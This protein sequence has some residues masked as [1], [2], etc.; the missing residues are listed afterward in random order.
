MILPVAVRT[1]ADGPATRAAYRAG[2]RP[3]R[4]LLTAP[5]LTLAALG[6]G[7][8]SAPASW[9]PTA[10]V[11][12]SSGAW[13]PELAVNARGDAAVAWSPTLERQSAT[14][15]VR[16][17]TRRGPAGTFVTRTVMRRADTAIG[18][19]TVA[20]DP[21]GEAT[22]AWVERRS[23]R[24]LLSGPISVKAAYRRV[25]Q[26]WS[27]PR[28]IARVSPFRY[29]FPRLAAR[30]D[31]R[32]VLAFNAGNRAAPGVA[33]VWRGP[34]A[35]FGAVQA[36]NTGPR[37]RGYL[38]DLQVQFDAV[39]KGHLSGVRDC[40]SG[41]SSAVLFTS[42]PTRR[43]FTASRLLAPAPVRDLSLVLTSA[44]TGTAAWLAASC[45]TTEHYAGPVTAASLR[46]GRIGAPGTIDASPGVEL[47]LSGAPDD[48]AEASWTAFPEGP[49][50]ALVRVARADGDGVFGAPT[51]PADGLVALDADGAGTQVVVPQRPSS[52][53]WPERIGARV[54]DGRVAYAN[55]PA[56]RA[57]A[58]A[59]A[60][61]G[62][63]GLVAA[64]ARGD[65]IRISTWRP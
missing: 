7:A 24:G 13:T 38:F 55:L 57:F 23:V 63:T 35:R 6:V 61:P 25:G 62:G 3:L 4:H 21:R 29:S 53:G 48:G 17:A 9:S 15:F 52:F 39:G 46:S 19:L 49:V 33:A 12:G 51:A 32:V 45:S 40:D 42:P 60:H 18:G 20:L 1:P 50:E 27:T 47:E 5:A 8:P 14:G 54:A 16:V 43:R 2:M 37:G 22:I 41:R 28:L 31:G 26:S 65:G 34:G 36:L 59:A 56:G 64:T 30:P 58:H 44:G 10:R 11:P